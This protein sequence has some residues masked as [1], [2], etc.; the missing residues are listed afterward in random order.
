MMRSTAVAIVAAGACAMLAGCS[1]P[2]G[3]PEVR[4]VE[5]VQRTPAR[6]LD[7]VL[8]TADELAGILGA[9]GFIGQLVEGGPDMLLEG[10]RAAEA[11]PMDCVSA[12][13]R[14][15]KVVYE[16]SPVRSVASRPWAGGDAGGPSVTGF[17]GVVQFGELDTARAFFAESADNWHRCNGQTLVLS[18]PDRGVQAAS[19]IAEVAVDGRMV[20]AVVMH[21]DGSVVQRALGI[22]ADCVVDVEVSDVSGPAATGASDAVAV[23]D[24]ML[25][26][27]GS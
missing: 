7:Q 26:K 18:Q 14:L 11:S 12:G 24:L 6:A 19:R 27:I 25:Q 10:V 22:G 2:H 13:Y 16:A 8:P 23:A 21:D 20:S 15:Q 17:F 1:T 9:G 4:I 5:A 3:A